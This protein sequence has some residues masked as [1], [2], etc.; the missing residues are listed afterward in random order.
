MVR[1]LKL[2]LYTDKQI[3]RMWKCFPAYLETHQ[4]EKRHPLE[5]G[6]HSI[7]NFISY[8]L[9]AEVNC[10][11]ICWLQKPIPKYGS[12][13]SHTMHSGILTS[14]PENGGVAHCFTVRVPAL[15]LHPSSQPLLG[16]AYCYPSAF[17]V[18]ESFSR[19]QCNARA[20]LLTLS[21]CCLSHL[22]GEM[23]SLFC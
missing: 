19:S 22:L 5:F 3:K 8:P 16:Q 2:T 10:F 4:K 17:D 14:M 1:Q 13:N 6:L 23:Q 11:C 21:G 12:C 7:K 20:E 15:A 18:N 9:G